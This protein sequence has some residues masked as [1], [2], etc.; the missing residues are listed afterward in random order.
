MN[1]SNTIPKRVPAAHE[2]VARHPTVMFGR[3]YPVS[4]TLVFPCRPCARSSTIFSC[5]PGAQC[6]CIGSPRS[7]TRS[8]G[9][10]HTA[11]TCAGH[12]AKIIGSINACGNMAK[13]G[14][15]LGDVGT[16]HTERLLRVAVTI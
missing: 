12:P 4:S 6:C 1:G 11:H 10:P 14:S 3:V 8:Y 9:A 13:W 5:V 16:V 2:Q 7:V 15:E